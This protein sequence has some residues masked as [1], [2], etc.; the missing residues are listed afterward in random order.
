MR[1]RNPNHHIAETRDWSR[2]LLSMG[3]AI[4]IVIVAAQGELTIAVLTAM[5]AL[6][7]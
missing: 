6:L 3:I 1:R 7:R 4:A 5:G 2:M